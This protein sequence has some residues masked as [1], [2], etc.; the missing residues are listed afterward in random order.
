MEGQI[1]SDSLHSEPSSRRN[2]FN[3]SRHHGHYPGADHCDQSLLY[4]PN[5]QSRDNTPIVVTHSS[6]SS[7]ACAMPEYY[8]LTS[9]SFL[10]SIEEA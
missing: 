1:A 3:D 5:A 6:S 7:Q 9:S 8:T 2:S 4:L 10:V